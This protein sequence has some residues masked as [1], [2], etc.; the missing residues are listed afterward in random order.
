SNLWGSLENY[1]QS[2]LLPSVV[3]VGFFTAALSPALHRERMWATVLTWTGESQALL[4]AFVSLLLSFL[5][6]SVARP[7]TRLLEGYTLGPAWL[8]ARWEVSQRKKREEL[9]DEIDR[10]PTLEHKLFLRERA[11]QYPRR[12]DLVLAT[13]LG[14]ALR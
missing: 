3:A 12:E 7:V 14:N 5:L 6:A 1:I 10:A 4:F 2:W 8:K 11:N 9:L 13:R